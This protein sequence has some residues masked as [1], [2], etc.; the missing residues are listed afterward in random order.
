MGSAKKFKKRVTR[1]IRRPFEWLGVLLGIAIFSSLPHRALVA[2]A[3]FASWIMY[4]FDSRGRRRSLQNLRIIF[5]EA[6]PSD[7]KPTRRETYIIKRSYRNMARAVAHAFWTFRKARRRV[8]EVGEMCPE[9]KAFLAANKTAVTVSGHIGCWEILSQLAFLEGHK[10]MSVAKDIGSSGMTKLLMKSRRSIGQEIVRSEGA[11]KFLLKGLKEGK[12]LGLLVDQAVRPS[13]GGIWIRFFSRPVPVSAAPAFFSAKCKAPIVV[14]W[15]RP[16]KNGRYRCEV[17]SAYKPEDAR[18][19]W[20]M[21]QRCIKDLEGV[22][23]RHPSCWVLNYNAFRKT[24]KPDD[25]VKLAEN[26]AKTSLPEPLPK[27][28]FEGAPRMKILQVL[29]ALQQGGVERGTIEVASALQA[30]GIENAVVSAGGALVAEL[31]KIGVPHY[32]IDAKTKNPFKICA[33]AK[34]IARIATEGGFTLMHVRS[35]APAW[36]VKKASKLTGIP[37]ISTFHGL[38]GTKPRIFK[39]PYNRVM[40]QGLRTIAVSD[41]VKNH[42]LENYKVDA[43]KIIRIHR[44][45]DTE[46]F[47][48]DSVAPEKAIEFKRSLGFEDSTRVITLPGRLT[49]WKGQRELIAAAAMMKSKSFGLLFVGSDQGRKEYSDSLREQA[50]KLPAPIKTVFL[51]HSSDMPLIYAMS[52]I[53][54]SASSAQP[55]AFGRVI[56]EAQAMG[57]LV[58]GTAHGGA[59]ETVC[60]GKTGFLVPPGDIKALA[61]KLDDVL[62][63]DEDK[64]REIALDAVKSCRE[65]FSIAKMCSSTIDLYRKI[66]LR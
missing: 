61:E 56:P 27:S 36:S 24:P 21:T 40:L 20:G 64:K 35:R 16:L 23:R 13:D 48:P 29:P 45:A 2:V 5:G 63:L 43:N 38:Y 14:A 60:D 3:D 53:V 28:A 57:R 51:D 34:K 1:I 33:N 37:F 66:H 59:C 49:Y 12:S 9:G 18:N 30:A 17:V 8:C 52:E 7:S 6:N 42:I 65:N 15:S 31:E 22:I 25:L 55:E 46:V 19:V 54:V 58:V 26:E 41:C 44:G 11:F 4:T 50:A 32:T 10:M 62:A 39:I 47:R